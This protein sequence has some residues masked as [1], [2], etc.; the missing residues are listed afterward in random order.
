VETVRMQKNLPRHQQLLEQLRQMD[1]VRDEVVQVRGEGEPDVSVREPIAASVKAI[2]AISDAQSAAPVPDEACCMQAAGDSI[3]EESISTP[4][5]FDLESLLDARTRIEAEGEEL[6]ARESRLKQR[7]NTLVVEC[8]LLM[9]T[10]ADA[11]ST[12]RQALA[13]I[14]AQLMSD[15]TG[16]VV[17]KVHVTDDFVVQLSGADGVW[18]PAERFSSAI[19]TL[20]DLALCLTPNQLRGEGSRLPLLL[21]DPLGA[22]DKKRRGQALKVL[23]Q[24]A[25]GAQVILFSHDEAVRRRAMRDGWHLISLRAKGPAV[26][27][28]KEEKNDDDGQLSFL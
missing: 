14:L 24:Y 7:R 23:E 5:A 3:I 18:L 4:G 2:A 9:E 28:G 15:L 20:H 6:R 22:L 1:A 25:A 27:V 12:D 10:L 17:D 16:G 26:A 21:D 13:G 19:R 8:D 11:P